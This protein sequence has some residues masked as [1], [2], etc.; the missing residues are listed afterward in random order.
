MGLVRQSAS[1]RHL[2]G[3][4]P[5]NYVARPLSR[6]YPDWHENYMQEARPCSQHNGGPMVSRDDSIVITKNSKPDDSQSK[7]L[8][9]STQ[10]PRALLQGTPI[11]R[12]SAGHLASALGWSMRIPM[13]RQDARILRCS[14][15]VPRNRWLA[16]RNAVSVACGSAGSAATAG[17]GGGVSKGQQWLEKGAFT[18][19][20][21]G[22]SCL[23]CGIRPGGILGVDHLCG[24]SIES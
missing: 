5:S 23:G 21:W 19:S 16:E 8:T 2:L 14:A 9:I 11:W 17:R 15:Q 13:A 1:L 22:M 24:R 4:M 3:E 10:K 6:L 18:A 7:S 20:A 12:G